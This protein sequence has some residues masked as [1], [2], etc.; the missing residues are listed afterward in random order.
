MIPSPSARWYRP[1]SEIDVEANTQQSEGAAYLGLAL[2][3]RGSRKQS[4]ALQGRKVKRSHETASVAVAQWNGFGREIKSEPWFRFALRGVHKQTREIERTRESGGVYISG[5]VCPRIGINLYYL[6]KLHRTL[7]GGYRATRHRNE[8]RYGVPARDS[9]YTWKG[10]S[11][12]AREAT[13]S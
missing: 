11:E 6:A 12:S 8:M 1:I 7:D 9:S 3:P 10:S 2:E 5:N 13:C 4:S